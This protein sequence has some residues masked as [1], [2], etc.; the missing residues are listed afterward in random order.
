MKTV[1]ITGANKGIGFE[2]AKQLAQLGYFVYLGSRDKIKGTEAIKKLND[3][4][5]SNVE[6]IQI[7]IA[8][9]A[10]IKQAKQ[11]IE[12]KVNSLDILINNGGIAGE[13]PQHISSFD[14]DKLRELFNVNYFG[15][16]QTTQQFI[17]LLEKSDTPR[18][19]NV[20]SEV[21]SLT[22]NT[23]PDRKDRWDIFNA[24]GSSKTALNSF[25][26]MLANEF[27]NTKFKVI[28]VTPGFTATDINQHRGIKT[29]EEGAS[30]I[31]RSVVSTDI[32]TRKFYSEEGEVPW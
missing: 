25:T 23:S 6:Q 14:I 2:T 21:G 32:E 5:I 12:T 13:Q 30:P 26:V 27:R 8:D 29:V 31:V 7:D 16:V 28:S 10:S 19:I 18:I 11:N 24:Y 17:P 3:L 22:L 15:V 9:I 20:S 1:F 4:G